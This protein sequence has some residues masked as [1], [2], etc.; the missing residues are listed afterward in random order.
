MFARAL[1]R[2]NLGQMLVGEFS[3]EDLM[4]RIRYMLNEKSI[5]ESSLQL[6]EKY[7]WFD[8]KTLPQVIAEEISRDYSPT[9]DKS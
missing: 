1:C 9:R 6:A 4:T 8:P 5:K 7:A 3:I 2:N